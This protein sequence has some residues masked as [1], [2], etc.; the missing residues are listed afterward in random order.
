VLTQVLALCL[1]LFSAAPPAQAASRHRDEIV[2]RTQRLLI[3]GRVEAAAQTLAP[4]LGKSRDPEAELLH[5]EL[6][7]YQGEYE[8]A[9][10][11]L[12]AGLASVRLPSAEAQELR[13]LA[14]LAAA[15]AEVT[16]GFAEQRSPGGHFLLRYRRGKDEVLIPYA[17]EALEKAWAAIG[18]DF[19]GTLPG[20][21]EAAR[22]AGPVR[23][24]IYGDVADLA[25]V[26]TLTIKEIETSGTI[27]LCK[28]NRLMIVS[29]RALLRG[30]PWLDTLTHEYT[31]Y[32]VT[33]VSRGAAPIW[34]HEGLAKFEE[35]R[36]RGL[37]GGGLTPTLEHFLA[38][39]LAKHRFITFEQMSP[40]MAKLPSQEDTAL[41]FAEVYT[42][43]EYLHGKFGWNGLRQLLAEIGRGT[44]DIRALGSVYGGGYAEFE[45]GWKTWLRGKKLRSRAGMY[46]ARLRFK[47]TA[48]GARGSGKN[49]QAPAPEDDDS[50]EISDPKARSFVRLGGLLRARGRLIAAAVEYE[51]AQGVLGPGHPLLSLKLGRTYLELGEADHAIAALEP[52]RETYAD[53]PGLNAALGSAW[54]KKGDLRKAVTYLEAAIAT[55]PFDPATH[56][57]LGQAY[58]ELKSPLAERENHACSLLSGY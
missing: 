7:F 37:S 14:D 32:I 13:S 35:R 47:K 3:E 43:V 26:S 29:P 16:H 48:P 42:A 19:A 23:V 24:E 31:H 38:A 12:R 45:R 18:E 17:A 21:D 10:R 2:V 55:S 51:K 58:R 5:G 33:R 30:Y 50:G 22:P 34:L 54:L 56:C 44:G 46:T 39:A 53:L 25:R 8:A 49:G 40:S 52:A 15:S 1:P 41:A 57:G 9:A 6:L 20:D 28:W 4:L 27:A 36:W 11:T